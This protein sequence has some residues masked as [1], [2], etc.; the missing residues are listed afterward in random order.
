MRSQSKYKYFNQRANL[1]LHLI[2]L[3]KLNADVCD[4]M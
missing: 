2:L 1:E 3:E 4:A